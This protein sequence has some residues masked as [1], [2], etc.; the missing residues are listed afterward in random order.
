MPY[1]NNKLL[2]EKYRQ[3]KG[4]ETD[5]YRRYN[6]EYISC[7]KR[8]VIIEEAPIDII[9]FYKDKKTL[10]NLGIEGIGRFT[11]F[12]LIYI[13]KELEKKDEKESRKNRRGANEKRGK[14]TKR[15]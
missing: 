9:K 14:T 3:L 13:I 8:A 5:S 1:K 6:T 12:D 4:P 7:L 15:A 2:A 10:E 11:R